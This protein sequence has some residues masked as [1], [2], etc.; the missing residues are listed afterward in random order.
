LSDFFIA[1]DAP[2]ARPIQAILAADFQTYLAGRPSHIVKLCETADFQAQRGRVLLVPA[3]DGSL[4]RVLFGLGDVP[5]PMMI[6][7][8]SASLPSGDY[9]LSGLPRDMSPTLAAMAWALG[10]YKYSH[11]KKSD[12]VPPRLLLMEGADAADARRLH[13]ATILVRDLVNTPPNLMGPEGLEAAARAVA[14]R[15]GASIEVVS[16]DELTAGY[17]LVAAVGRASAEAPRY[18]EITWGATDARKVALVG[19]GVTF[20]SGGLDLK[21]ASN[22]RLMKKDMGGAAHALGVAQYLMDSDAPIRLSVHI[23]IVENAVGAGAFRPSD[24]IVSRAGLSVEIDDTD[25][26]GRLILADALTRASELEPELIIDFAT[27]TGAARVAVG[28]EIAPF[29]ANQDQLAFDIEAASKDMADPVWRLPLW[30]GYEADLESPVAN[31]KNLGGPMGG[32]ITAALF[33][34]RFVKAPAWAHFD[35]YSWN[36]KDRPGRPAGGEAQGLRA[37]AKMIRKR[38]G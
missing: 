35:V 2:G 11:F 4:E 31:I 6:S 3:S 10:A 13:A 34:K 27:L 37:V 20:D 29:F 15:C 24:V 25:A 17:P 19:K 33:L 28:P 22:M 14:E 23:P 16:G 18:V 8:L 7:G 30:A 32:A 26:E 36:A 5:D 12:R 21:S 38:F 9:S 1:G